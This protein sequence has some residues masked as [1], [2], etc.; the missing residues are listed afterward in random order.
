MIQETRAVQADLCCQ[1]CKL[2]NMSSYR[3]VPIPYLH[4]QKNQLDHSLF[5][6]VSL[7]QALL[8]YV[9]AQVSEEALCHQL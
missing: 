4:Q 6:T 5:H 7:A 3:R 1:F 8:L 2:K 9:P